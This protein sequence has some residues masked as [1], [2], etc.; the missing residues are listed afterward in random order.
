[1]SP[2][3]IQA[4]MKSTGLQTLKQDDVIEDIRPQVLDFDDGISMMEAVWLGPVQEQVTETVP[5][6]PAA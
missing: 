3:I 5:E 6:V 4:A 2:D 1:M